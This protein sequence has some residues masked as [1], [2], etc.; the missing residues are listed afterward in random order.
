MSR[1]QR[2]RHSHCLIVGE[3]TCART[4]TLVGHMLKHDARVLRVTCSVNTC[5]V[6]VDTDTVVG[7]PLPAGV[8]SCYLEQRS[9]LVAG[10]GNCVLLAC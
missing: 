8:C 10:F 2:Q 6:T 4:L 5:T 3:H 7:L 9:P 1:P